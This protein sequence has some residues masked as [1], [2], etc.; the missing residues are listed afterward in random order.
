MLSVNLG[1]VIVNKERTM[2]I[3]T[4][5]SIPTEDLGWVTLPLDP[6]K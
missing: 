4:L 2:Y 1:L 6:A 3:D 5:L